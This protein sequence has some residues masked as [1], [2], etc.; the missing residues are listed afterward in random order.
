MCLFEL[1]RSH[2]FSP[3]VDWINVSEPSLWKPRVIAPGEVVALDFVV[4]FLIVS[5]ELINLRLT[6][7]VESSKR[8]SP[9][10]RGHGDV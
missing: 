1:V 3:I 8:G 10:T 6:M 7:S 2:V 5:L 4:L 9:L